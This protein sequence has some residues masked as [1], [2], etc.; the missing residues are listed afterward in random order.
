M[1]TIIMW[2]VTDNNDTAVQGYKPAQAQPGKGVL[3]ICHT[4]DPRGLQCELTPNAV[5]QELTAVRMV[6]A[7]RSISHLLEPRGVFCIMEVL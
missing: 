6:R 1:L 4:W 7:L 2:P 5:L 3:Q